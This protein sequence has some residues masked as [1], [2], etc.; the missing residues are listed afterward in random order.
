MGA[1]D[2]EGGGMSD[3]HNAAPEFVRAIGPVARELMGEPTEESASKG[4]MR[5]GTRG[6]LSVN[7]K[8]GTWFDHEADEGG[9]LIDLVKRQ[10]SVD[11]DGAVDWLRKQG[12]LAKPA[13]PRMIANYP[14]TD[15]AGNLLFEVCRFEP[16]DFRQ[17]RPNGSGGWIWKM[18][19][20]QR[21]IY[22]LPA[23]ADA[24]AAGALVYVVEGEKAADT[25]SAL[26]V[27]AT[28]SPGGANKWR[29]EYAT[30]LAGADV[31]ILPDND[32]PGRS[33]GAMVAASLRTRGANS[34]RIV[35]LPNLPEKG[36][37]ADWIAAGGTAADLETL[38]T[39][40]PEPDPEM[41][42]QSD[43]TADAAAQKAADDC[44]VAIGA[45]V[46]E[47]NSRYLVVNEAGKATI[48][49][50]GYDPVLRRRHYDRLS[51]RDLTTLY[52]GSLHGLL[53]TA[54]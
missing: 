40:A 36:D 19:G 5:F 12:H 1:T 42:D 46:T 23:V 52:M 45:A 31:V 10:R 53:K 17:R 18:T 14:Y 25:L 47:F 20:V 32:L 21:V 26:G 48:L 39:S 29:P 7:L 38:V 51:V 43:E 22:R 50:P 6:S 3:L 4:E 15:T 11:K 33:H 28:C 9:G 27:T 13:K 35:T 24:I 49:Q 30:H 34:V 8:A 16:K 54:R 44:A 2:G 41:S 37:V